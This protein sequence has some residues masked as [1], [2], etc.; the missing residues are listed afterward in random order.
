[1][2]LSTKGLFATLSITQHKRHTQHN[3]NLYQ[4]PLFRGSHFDYCYAE[5]FHAKCHFA[6]C[7]GAILTPKTIKLQA[8]I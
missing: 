5:C 4:V 1:M 6:E 8:L 7:R 2:K 3:I